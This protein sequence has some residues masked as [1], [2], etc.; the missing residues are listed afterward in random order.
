MNWIC[1]Q[2]GARERYNY[3]VVLNRIDRLE[4]LVTDIWINKR[5]PLHNFLV[6]IFPSLSSRTNENIPHNKV[7]SFNIIFIPLTIIERLLQLVLNKNFSISIDKTYQKKCVTYLKEYLSDNND[8]KIVFSYN[9]TAEKIFELS[10]KFKML[11]VLG[12]ID[13]GPEAGKINRELYKRYFGDQVKPNDLY[14]KYGSKWI[15]ECTLANSIIVNS[16]WSKKLLIKSGVSEKKI[17]I[18]PVVYSPTPESKLFV[19]TY[20]EKFTEKRPLRVLF[21]GSIKLMKGVPL[22]LDVARK[23]IDKPVQFTLVGHL[24]MPARLLRNLSPNVSI[25]KGVPPQ[26]ADMFYQ[27][28]DLFILPTYS[29]G[30]AITQLEAQAWKL[31]VLVSKNCGNVVSDGKNGW[32]LNELSFSEVFKKINIVLEDPGLLDVASKNANDLERFSHGQLIKNL[33][34][35]ENEIKEN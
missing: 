7:K 6:A 21:L 1:F 14:L 10:K 16:K 32:I 23:L 5:K 24:K 29:D 30:F 18:I 11:T 9:Y 27:N 34:M 26:M 13:A 33:V 4:L 19:R 8:K 20:P 3:P 35:F 12:Q 2:I 15:K 25:I 28:S 22:I 31:P 17:I